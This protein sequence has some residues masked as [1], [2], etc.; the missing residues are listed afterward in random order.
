[1]DRRCDVLLRK[2]G[3]REGGRKGGRGGTYQGL[4]LLP[5][6]VQ[7]GLDLSQGGNKPLR[8]GKDRGGRR[9]EGCEEKDEGKV[10]GGGKEG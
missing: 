4:D 7:L 1:M 5:R 9:E 10:R 6:G 8:R 2:E 3:G